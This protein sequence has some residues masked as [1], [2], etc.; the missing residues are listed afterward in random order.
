MFPVAAG[1]VASCGNAGKA[2]AK[3]TRPVPSSIETVL[4]FTAFLP[5][6]LRISAVAIHSGPVRSPLDH[7]PPQPC[8]CSRSATCSARRRARKRPKGENL[9][10]TQINEGRDEV[11]QCA[12]QTR[13]PAKPRPT[14]K[15]TEA[16]GVYNVLLPQAHARSARMTESRPDRGPRIQPACLAATRPHGEALLLA[17]RD[18]HALRRR[19]LDDLNRVVDFNRAAVANKTTHMLL[20]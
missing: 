13:G 19:A 20:I 16:H 3:T 18:P 5:S 4:A 6:C 17:R 10:V 11:R 8:I 9:A 2:A 7:L 12:V 14:R 1:F 15:F